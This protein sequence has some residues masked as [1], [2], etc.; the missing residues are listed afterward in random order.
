MGTVNV[1]IAPAVLVGAHASVSPSTA[2]TVTKPAG[3]NGII[4]QAVTAD[5]RYTLDGTTPDG[6]TGFVLSATAAASTISVPSNATLKVYSATGTL[7]YQWIK[8]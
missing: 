7:Q 4:L 3:A 5:V 6:T 8:S 2:A 1:G